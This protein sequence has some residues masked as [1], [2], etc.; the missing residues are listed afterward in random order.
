MAWRG[1]KSRFRFMCRMCLRLSEIPW[2]LKHRKCL[3]PL[4]SR[5]P[6]KRN[7]LLVGFS[8]KP[9]HQPTKTTKNLR[10]Q[11]TPWFATVRH[12][13]GTAPFHVDG[14][15]LEHHLSEIHHIVQ[16]GLRP[17]PRELKLGT[18]TRCLCKQKKDREKRR[19]KRSGLSQI[20]A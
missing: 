15:E 19:K 10:N 11:T 4:H 3:I 8:W 7:Q 13:V 16:D 17:R 9:N 20:L 14:V 12:S 18:S 5:S 2:Y 6:A 1:K